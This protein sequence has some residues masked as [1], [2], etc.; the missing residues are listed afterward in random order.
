MVDRTSNLKKSNPWLTQEQ[1]KKLREMIKNTQQW[2]SESIKAQKERK[3]HEDPSYFTNDL[4][5]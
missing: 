5:E 2:L 1:K 3:E 4:I